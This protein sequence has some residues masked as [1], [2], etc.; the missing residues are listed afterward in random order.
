MSKEY[1]DNQNL[2]CPSCKY[3]HQSEYTETLK[4]DK[5]FIPIYSEHTFKTPNTKERKNWEYD[6]KENLE[7]NLY[8][9]PY[10]GTVIFTSE[11]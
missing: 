2:K 4:G 10:C 1:C 8:G 6:Y 11:D 7:I 3:E 9:C 5:P